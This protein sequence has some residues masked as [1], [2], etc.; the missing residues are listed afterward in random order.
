MGGRLGKAATRNQIA[1]IA[2][3]LESR[4]YTIKGGGG[5]KPEE[6]LKP[7]AGGKKGGSYIDITASHPIHG[8]LRINT[9]D[10]TSKGLPT[11]REL[12]NATRIRSQIAP[13]EHLLLIPK[14]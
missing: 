10:V 1:E 5:I 11:T 13:G 12:I 7:L 6:Y 8:T 4:G 14:K 3:E 9:V 2:A